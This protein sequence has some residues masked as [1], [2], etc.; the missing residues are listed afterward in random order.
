MQMRF[1]QS[2]KYVKK[3]LL[4]KTHAALKLGLHEPQL[5]VDWS[6]TFLYSL[7]VERH[8]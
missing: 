4:R 3:I 5:Q 2:N 1:T 6:I 7:V 8:C